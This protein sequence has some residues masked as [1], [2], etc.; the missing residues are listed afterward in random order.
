MMAK[1]SSTVLTKLFELQVSTDTEDIE[2]M[3]AA[4]AKKH[5]ADLEAAVAKHAGAVAPAPAK[6][7]A[8]QKKPAAAPAIR[9]ND[10][11]PCGSGKK[12]R[13]CHGAALDD[14]AA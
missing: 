7:A 4:A 6:K 9:A 10:P 12:F 11:C 3:E 5:L 13:E 8:Q 2:A 1:V 14:D